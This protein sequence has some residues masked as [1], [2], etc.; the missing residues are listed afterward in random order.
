MWLE[1]WRL[2]TIAAFSLATLLMRRSNCWRGSDF[3]IAVLAA[4]RIYRKYEIDAVAAIS[5]HIRF[6]TKLNPKTNP[7]RNCRNHVNFVFAIDA[8][9]CENSNLKVRRSP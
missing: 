6:G 1:K 5:P 7:L 9:C 4:N 2:C 3:E 8:I